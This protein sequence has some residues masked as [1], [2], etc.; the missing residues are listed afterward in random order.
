MQTQ[1]SPRPALVFQAV[2]RKSLLSSGT[3][4]VCG[5]NQVPL[6][7]AQSVPF[8][9]CHT[10]SVVQLQPNQFW[11][12][13]PKKT[14]HICNVFMALLAHLSSLWSLNE[15][16][17]KLNS[18]IDSSELNRSSEWVLVPEAPF[19]Q[20]LVD[21]FTWVHGMGSVMSF[22][23]SQGQTVPAV[24]LMWVPRWDWGQFYGPEMGSAVCAA[25][26]EFTVQNSRITF[27]FLIMQQQNSPERGCGPRWC[28]EQWKGKVG[29]VV[30]YAVPLNNVNLPQAGGCLFSHFKVDITNTL[31]NLHKALSLVKFF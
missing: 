9:L 16:Y 6:V 20:L 7:S 28:M 31:R 29:T 1:K 15:G 23:H 13:P 18:F 19:C 5:Y 26:S 11:L 21:K 10:A 12:E 17:E 4:K 8:P 30:L 27:F 22:L 25:V 3:G 24:G 2:E 14:P